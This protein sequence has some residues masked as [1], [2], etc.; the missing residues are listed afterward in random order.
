MKSHLIITSTVGMPREDWLRFRKKGIGASD[1]GTILG[2]NP[3]KSALELFYERLTPDPEFSVE[4]IAMFMGREQEDFIADLWQFWEGSQETMMLNY[5]ADK[6]IRKCQRVNGIVQNPKYPWLFVNLDRKINKGI[7]GEEG[8]LELK[9]IAGYEADKWEAGIPTPYMIQVLTQMLVCEFTFGE[10]AV[11]KDGRNFEVYPFDYNEN[12]CNHIIETTKA[13][14]DKVEMGRMYLTQE[15]EARKNFNIQLA[16]ECHAKL[17]MLEPAPD[18]S[19]GYEKFMREKFKKNIAEVGLIA[20]TDLDWED[21]FAI[22]K[23]KEEI[24]A[25]EEEMQLHKNIIM[26]RIGGMR[27]LDF[28]KRGFISWQGEPRRFLVK[29]KP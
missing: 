20:G 11:F 3:Y 27:K 23:L 4:N 26:R 28:G 19:E 13:F 10:L 8:A 21:A 6:I 12:I 24:K 16:D 25:R 1:V 18:G 17:E 7:K 29:L 9:T 22:H 15:F 5:R 14:W 2:M